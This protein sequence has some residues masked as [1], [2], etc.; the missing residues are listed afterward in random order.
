MINDD[1]NFIAQI[2]GKMGMAC[3]ELEA[4]IVLGLIT[5]NPVMADGI[6]LF[7]PQH[8]NILEG[9]HVIDIDSTSTVRAMMRR[10]V[11]LDGRKLN[12]TPANYLV[13]TALETL[14]EQF[15]STNLMAD[16][17]NKINPFAGRLGV[18]CDVRLDD[19][20]PYDW[21]M[22]AAPT[23]GVELI[24]AAYLN[25]AEGPRFESRMGFETSG[26]EL[27][28]SMDFGAGLIDHRGIF[29]VIGKQPGRFEGTRAG[30]GASLKPRAGKET[31]TDF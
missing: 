3:A 8:N 20:S 22:V 5:S 2:P 24:E 11:G 13:P 10:H 16:A 28:C 14:S 4:N 23:S 15:I 25:G 19:S 21:Y 29:K 17:T 9:G 6:P 12:I 31:L 1:L 7:D 18:L 26:M 27:K 30:G